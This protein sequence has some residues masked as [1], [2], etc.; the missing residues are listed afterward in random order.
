MMRTV[1]HLVGLDRQVT[2][3]FLFYTI[4]P[5]PLRLYANTMHAPIVAAEDV[6]PLERPAH[7]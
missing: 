6:R 5:N 4:F 7:P 3:L 2:V 1:T